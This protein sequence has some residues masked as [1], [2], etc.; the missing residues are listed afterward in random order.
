MHSLSDEHY[1][2]RQAHDARDLNS[3]QEC[4]LRA[5]KNRLLVLSLCG[6]GVVVEGSGVRVRLELRE[7]VD[8]VVE[9]LVHA[10]ARL[11]PEYLSLLVLSAAECSTVYPCFLDVGVLEYR[12]RVQV[13][14]E[15]GR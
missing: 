15:H 11:D 6:V 10:P 14:A 2:F 9:V 1:L 8:V 4:G 13:R 7:G 12:A 3:A 5:H